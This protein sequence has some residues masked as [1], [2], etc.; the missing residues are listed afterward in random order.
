MQEHFGKHLSKLINDSITFV[1]LEMPPP[2]SKR[3]KPKNRIKLLK[4]FTEYIDMDKEENP[5]AGPPQKRPTILKTDQ[6]GLTEEEKLEQAKIDSVTILSGKETENWS[7]H[8]KGEKFAYREKNKVL[9]L[10]EPETEFTKQMKKNNWSLTK[11]SRNYKTKNK[12][13]NK[14]IE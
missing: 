14:K 13:K 4:D 11:I 9:Y 3:K 5:V 1:D 10:V 8:T 7:S 12:N 2:P 6:T